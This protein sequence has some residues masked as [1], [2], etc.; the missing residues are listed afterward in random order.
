MLR[1]HLPGAPR[2]VHGGHRARPP[3]PGRQGHRLRTAQAV[4]A[5]LPAQ[6]PAPAGHLASG[7]AGSCAMLNSSA[8]ATPP[9]PPP[10][11]ACSPARRP[12]RFAPSCRPAPTWWPS[13]A[14]TP[15]TA[16]TTSCSS[17][18]WMRPTWP[19]TA[20]CWCTPPAA[21]PRWAHPCSRL[22]PPA[23]AAHA[24]SLP[25]GAPVPCHGPAGKFERLPRVWP[26]AHW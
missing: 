3:L 20:W 26:S 19:R 13:S 5:T 1:L 11:A 12:S 4:R 18:R 17:A 24:S 2:R 25:L 21:P 15:S 8:D 22:P 9:F 14:A 6:R 7:P 16:R 23:V 10:G